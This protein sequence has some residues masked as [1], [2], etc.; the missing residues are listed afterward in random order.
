MRKRYKEEDTYQ[1]VVGVE[2][3]DDRIPES[4]KLLDRV[5]IL[6]RE[7]VSTAVSSREFLVD[8]SKRVKGLV[9][10]TEIVDEETE[11]I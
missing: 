3:V 7:F 8:S 5:V 2:L 1:L 9:D 6:K 11:S 4:V 10:V